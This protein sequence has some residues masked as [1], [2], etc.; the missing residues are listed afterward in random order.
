MPLVV[1]RWKDFILLGVN[2]LGDL[3][4][5]QHNDAITKTCQGLYVL[6]H[7]KRFVLLQITLNKLTLLR[8]RKY[9]DWL[10][11][12]WYGNSSPQE[13]E[14]LQGVLHQ[15]ASSWALLSPPLKASPW[16]QHL[17]SIILIRV[18]QEYRSLK[19]HETRFRNS[20]FS[21]PSVRIS[22]TLIPLLLSTF[23]QL[24]TYFL[25]V[26]C[27]TLVLSSIFF[28]LSCRICV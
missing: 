19:S 9:P 23:S 8:F 2:I 17:S 25:T 10:H 5:A 27:S 3:S 28:S 14:R 22:T 7:L 15:L 24:R 4:V 20:Y 11:H 18:R 13:C 1:Q 21:Q 6:R 16:G 12:A 26:F